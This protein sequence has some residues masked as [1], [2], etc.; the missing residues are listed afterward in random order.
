MTQLKGGVEKD[1]NLDDPH[2]ASADLS[3]FNNDDPS[4]AS[5]SCP[6]PPSS[7]S[8]SALEDA[9]P[10]APTK[11]KTKRTPPPFSKPTLGNP[12]RA[13]L[14]NINK[15]L[16]TN[17]NFQL[18]A[19]NEGGQSLTPYVPRAG[20]SGTTLATGVDIGQM[21]KRE[22]QNLGLEKPLLDKLTPFAG[23]KRAK[24]LQALANA[25]KN[26]T[27][28]NLSQAEANKLDLL[29]HQSFLKS[30]LDSYNA[31]RQ[32]GV[33]DFT[34]LTPAQQTILMDL[35][36]NTGKGFPQTAAAKTF[37][38]DVAKG[39]WKDAEQALRDWKELKTVK[40]KNKDGTVTKTT[41][42]VDPP[43]WKQNRLNRD[44]DLLKAE[45]EKHD[46]K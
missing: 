5:G 24:A 39:D 27:L 9:V 3:N 18:L 36:Y 38:N 20:Q 33:V 25:E 14:A 40:T 29:F 30:T 41:E 46:K 4:K 32:K 45:R 11:N 44:A 43:K 23:L 28:P 2:Q 7:F 21:N 6:F 17:V 13:Q 19:N 12:D 10:K 42:W 35:T 16:G 15:T 8:L 34:K 26:G 22:I 37:Y 1:V 31:R